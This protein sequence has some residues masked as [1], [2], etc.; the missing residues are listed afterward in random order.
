MNFFLLDSDCKIVEA[1]LLQQAIV[2]KCFG[3]SKVMDRTLSASVPYKQAMAEQ[4]S[5]VT[6]VRFDT[7]KQAKVEQISRVKFVRFGTV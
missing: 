2:G 3:L 1:W 6:F 7:V 5:W 4:H